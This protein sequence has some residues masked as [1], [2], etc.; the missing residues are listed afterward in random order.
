MSKRLSAALI[1]TG[2]VLGGP[3]AV[4]TSGDRETLDD[5]G[6]FAPT[7]TIHLEET[8]TVSQAA[9]ARSSASAHSSASSRASASASV[10]SSATVGQA[11]TEGDC[12]AEAMATAEADGKRVTMR[13]SKQATHGQGPCRAKAR[14]EA[15]SDDAGAKAD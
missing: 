8:M 12:A 11:G 2:L 7:G 3:S 15:Q 5:P 6:P 9:S 10:R 14:A 1:I 4:A 13:D